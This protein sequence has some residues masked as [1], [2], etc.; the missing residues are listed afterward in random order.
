V[1]HL[2][3]NCSTYAWIVL[4]LLWPVAMLNYL[5]RQM[6]STIRASIHDVQFTLI[7]SIALV[8]L[9]V[10]VFLRTIRATVIAGVA[11]PFYWALWA[12]IPVA[13]AALGVAEVGA[14]ALRATSGRQRVV[15]GFT[16]AVA[17]VALLIPIVGQMRE[18][19]SLQPVSLSAVPQIRAQLGLKGTIITSGTY[20]PEISPFI[21]NTPISHKLPANLATVDTVLLGQ[22]RCRTLIDPTIRAFVATNVRSG[23]LRLVRS[24]RLFRV[25]VASQPLHAPSRAEIDSEPKGR[26]ADNC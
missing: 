6:V 11:L 8:V 9:V 21:P 18:V 13:L 19:Q 10:L 20:L 4:A 23:S 22:P 3:K 15:V 16:T 26:L 24:D 5:D 12:P 2:S 25:Y 17:V 14:L 7:L 1:N